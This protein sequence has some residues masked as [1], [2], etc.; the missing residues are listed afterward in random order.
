MSERWRRRARRVA[1]APALAAEAAPAEEACSLV[2]G[3][4]EGVAKA[5]MAEKGVQRRAQLGGAAVRFW[6]FG[7]LRALHREG[8]VSAPH[9]ESLFLL[10]QEK[11]PKEGRPTVSPRLRRGS[12]RVSGSGGVRRRHFCAVQS[13]L[14]AKAQGAHPCAP[15]RREEAHWTSSCFRLA[16]VPSADARHPCRAPSGAATA[17]VGDKA[18]FQRPQAVCLQG[19]ARRQWP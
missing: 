18:T 17:L 4:S 5:G 16:P 10:A 14:R 12:L 7:A 8:G 6:I 1:A 15:A 3:A 9:A 19:A 13:V 11:E 2:G